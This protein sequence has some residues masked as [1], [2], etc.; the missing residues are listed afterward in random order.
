[1][2]LNEDYFKNL[3]ITDEDIIEDVDGY[4]EETLHKLF[5]ANI[6]R[7]VMMVTKKP[8]VDYHKPENLKAYIDNIKTDP[9]AAAIK[10]ADRMHNMMT[11]LNKTL[12][13]RYRKAIETR[14]YYL[15][16]FHDC[17]KLYPRYENLF[18]AAKA[19]TA[20]LIYNIEAFYQ[21]NV[22]LQEQIKKMK[23]KINELETTS[24]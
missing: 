2:I 11:L 14:D 5:N 21:E 16:F 24:F 15:D 3:E 23:L 6:A 9:D 22:N 10:T 8:G 7:L 20:P 18:Y 4:T 13:A 1:M 12:D 17:R 19:Q